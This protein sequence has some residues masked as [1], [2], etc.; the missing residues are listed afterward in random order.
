MPYGLDICRLSLAL[1]NTGINTNAGPWKSDLIL[2][3]ISCIGLLKKYSRSETL[4][5][6]KIKAEKQT[7]GLMIPR[8]IRNT[9]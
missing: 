8:R 3:K 5:K 6:E 7:L 2:N 1:E 9:K 4:M